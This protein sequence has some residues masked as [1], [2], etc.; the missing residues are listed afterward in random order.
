[1]KRKFTSKSAFFSLRVETSVVVGL[2]S[3]CLAFVGFS[4]FPKALPPGESAAKRK[5][6]NP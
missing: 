1:M 3:L 5:R 6:H 2:A 4:A